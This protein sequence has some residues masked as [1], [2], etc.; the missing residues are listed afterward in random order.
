MDRVSI[1]SGRIFAELKELPT[2]TDAEPSLTGTAVTRVVF[3][4]RDLEARAWLRRLAEEAGFSVRVDPVGNTFVRL[5]GAEP[6]LAAVAIGSHI[7]AIPHAG[8]YDGTVGVLGGL[9]ALRSIQCSDLKPRRLIELILFT[10]EEPTRFGVGCL[11]SRML[12]GTLTPVDAAALKDP[13]GAS[14]EEV[15]TAAGFSGLPMHITPLLSFTLSRVHCSNAPT[16][17]SALS[18]RSPLLRV[19]ASRSRAWGPTRARSSCPTVATPFA[20]QPS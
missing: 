18:L 19:T 4:P 17:R 20:P 14:L 11:G 8:M 13:D 12:S 15:R 5:E 1:D 6:A 9:E 2:I 16:S 7:D 10:S 3:A